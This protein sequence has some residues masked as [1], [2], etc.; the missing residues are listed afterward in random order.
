MTGHHPVEEE[1]HGQKEH[2]FTACKKHSRPTSLN[3]Q[4]NIEWFSSIAG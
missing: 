1:D 4:P 2:V 3:Q